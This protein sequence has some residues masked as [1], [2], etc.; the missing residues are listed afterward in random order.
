MPA[1]L[2][3]SWCSHLAF[4]GL[5]SA[6]RAALQGWGVVCCD[7]CVP[8]MGGKWDLHGMTGYMK[9]S[10]S[11]QGVSCGILF[12]G[13]DMG[14]GFLG[15]DMGLGVVSARCYTNMHATNVSSPAAAPAQPGVRCCRHACFLPGTWW[16]QLARPQG[17]WAWMLSVPF[18]T[19]RSNAQSV[20]CKRMSAAVRVLPG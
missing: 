17:G 13:R 3:C 5:W 1:S 9:P 15:R 8:D 18:S 20:I 4:F 2:L 10:L 14:L 19:Y 11:V 6:A 12:L 7:L 16:G